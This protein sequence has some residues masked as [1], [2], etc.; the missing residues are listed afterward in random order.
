[1]L[2][3]IENRLL[4]AFSTFPTAANLLQLGLPII[5]LAI[6]LLLIGF[7]WGFLE[8]DVLQKSWQ[9]IPK[10]VVLSFIIPALAEETVFRVLFLPHP[11]ENPSIK[12][13][14]LWGAITLAAFIIY[15]PLQGLTWNPAGREVFMKPS[16]LILAALLGAMCTL[17]YLVVGSV[18]LPVIIHWLAVIVWLVLLGGY[19]QFAHLYSLSVYHMLTSAYF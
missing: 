2:H 17:A 4:T 6:M 15:H 13:Q 12:T 7:K 11:T 9:E 10:I 1:M 16:F 3:L 14:L 8:L 19:G 18:W 5:G